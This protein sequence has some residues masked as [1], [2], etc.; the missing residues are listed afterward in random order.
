MKKVKLYEFPMSHY[1]EKVRWALDLK[2]ARYERKLLLPVFHMPV[3]LALTRQTQVPVLE[4]DGVRIK[5]SADILR[6]IE[7]NIPGPPSL[8][9]SEPEQQASSDALCSMLDRDVGTHVRRVVYYHAMGDMAFMRELFSL[10]QTLANRTLTSAS[11]P[12]MVNAMRKAMGI[13]EKGYQRSLAILDERLKALDK[14][15]AS[16]DYLVGDRF[17][18]ADLTAASLLAPMVLPDK[19]FYVLPTGIPSSYRQ[20]VDSYQDRPFHAWVKRM[21]LTHR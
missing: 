21:Y 16:T 20:F 15:L 19:S 5:N 18:V 12:L 9:P 13:H 6:W 7:S 17:G 11:V 8:F 4:C 2:Q 10:E 14:R 3:M 1:C